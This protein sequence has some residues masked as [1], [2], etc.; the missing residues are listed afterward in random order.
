ML[1]YRDPF[2]HVIVAECAADPCGV[3]HMC[4]VLLQGRGRT[5]VYR[6]STIKVLN[7][8]LKC[9]AEENGFYNFKSIFNLQIIFYRSSTKFKCYN[10]IH[11]LSSI[12]KMNGL[13][14]TQFSWDIWADTKGNLPWKVLEM[15][16]LQAWNHFKYYFWQGNLFAKPRIISPSFLSPIACKND[17]FNDN[18]NFFIICVI[19]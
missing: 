9:W 15:W 12:W 10:K 7:A 17:N 11:F 18:L 14:E 6:L 3:L 19:H 5:S 2:P 13:S 4:Q 16:K 8:E 1:C